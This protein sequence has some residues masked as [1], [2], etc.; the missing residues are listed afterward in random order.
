METLRA[1]LEAARPGDVP[2]APTA[3]GVDYLRFT[4][5]PYE[6]EELGGIDMLW[7]RCLACQ[8]IAGEERRS[9]PVRV[10]SYE[11]KMVG[12]AALL[13]GLEGRVMVQ[14]SGAAA[15]AYV[16]AHGCEGSVSRL[17]VQ[18]TGRSDRPPDEALTRVYLNLLHLRSNWPYR[19]RA[20][21]VRIVYDRA[22]TVYSGRRTRNG[23]FVRC[24]NADAVHGKKGTEY[25]GAIRVEAEVTGKRATLWASELRKEQWGIV[26]A[27]E[28]ALGEANHRGARYV[29]QGF[30]T[31]RPPVVQRDMDGSTEATMEWLRRQVRPAVARLVS[32][33]VSRGAILNAIMPGTDAP[34]AAGV[35]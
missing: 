21:D 1:L 4:L 9:K 34:S 24:Y 22:V 31:A 32:Q 5:R 13:I 15:Q 18:V 25:Q 33:G 16:D 27:G 8:G 29:C 23:V 30:D 10:V 7:L 17:D 26:K 11:G 20:P 19:G 6:V 35:D 12:S 2:L 14:V 28:Q 3:A